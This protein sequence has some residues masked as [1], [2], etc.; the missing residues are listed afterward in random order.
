MAVSKEYARSM[1]ID[2]RITLVL[3]VPFGACTYVPDASM[4]PFAGTEMQGHNVAVHA[5]SAP[6]GSELFTVDLVQR[7]CALYV[8]VRSGSLQSA[9]AFGR[10]FDDDMVRWN[11]CS[12]GT[13]VACASVPTA[14]GDTVQVG[15]PWS[16]HREVGL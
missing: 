15:I 8:A 1:G 3:L 11:V 16:H 14:G 12:S 9:V 5:S 4:L 13:M 2:R 6:A 10:D 7:T